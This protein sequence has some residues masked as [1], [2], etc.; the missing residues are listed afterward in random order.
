MEAARVLNL[1]FAVE[2][3]LFYNDKQVSTCRR[4]VSVASKGMRE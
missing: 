3:L 1:Y 2:T 4:V